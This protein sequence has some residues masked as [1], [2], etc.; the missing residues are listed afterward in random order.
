MEDVAR[1]ESII[2]LPETAQ[3]LW[4]LC[5]TAPEEADKFLLQMARERRAK[6]QATGSYY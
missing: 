1:H 5:R 2:A 6:L 4:L 3:Q